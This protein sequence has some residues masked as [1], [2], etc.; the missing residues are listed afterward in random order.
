MVFYAQVKNFEKRLK[1]PGRFYLHDS[2]IDVFGSNPI[3]TAKKEFSGVLNKLDGDLLWVI[4]ILWGDRSQRIV[5]V[6]SY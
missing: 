2:G 3:P 5:E 1:F 4:G 6:F